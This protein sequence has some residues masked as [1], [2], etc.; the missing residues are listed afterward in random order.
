MFFFCV[1]DFYVQYELVVV[2]RYIYEHIIQLI[3]FYALQTQN[4]IKLDDPDGMNVGVI[5]H[6]QQIQMFTGAEF[7]SLAR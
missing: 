7:H 1:F 5:F 4:I 3:F 2:T 6:S